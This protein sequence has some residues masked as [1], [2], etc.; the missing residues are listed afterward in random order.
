MGNACVLSIFISSVAEEPMQHVTEIIAIAGKGLEND[1]Y[2]KN[3]GTFSS[4]TKRVTVRQAS[5]IAIEAINAANRALDVPFLPAETR[6]NIVIGG[7]SAEELNMLVG[8]EFSIGDAR[9]RGIELCTPCERP[10]KLSGKADFKKAFKDRGGLR[11]EILKTGKIT[12]GDAV[13]V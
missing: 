13:S 1:R 10:S 3:N 2:A 12:L 11:I 8:K 5:I 6:R 4:S 9:V 7:M